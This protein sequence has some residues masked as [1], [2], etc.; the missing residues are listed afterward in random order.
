MPL[1]LKTRAALVAAAAR[2]LHPY[3]TPSILARRSTSAAEDYHAWV[4]AEPE[5]PPECRGAAR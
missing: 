2:A 4:L 1:V 3:E 5:G